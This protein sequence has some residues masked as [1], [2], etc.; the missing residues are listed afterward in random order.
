MAARMK[1]TDSRRR[2][3]FR[4]PTVRFEKFHSGRVRDTISGCTVFGCARGGAAM[5]EEDRS[6]N[7]IWL[8]A[9]VITAINGG[10]FLAFFA[11]IAGL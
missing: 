7:G 2:E 1:T 10:L 9:I 8:P 3:K 5:A 11:G 6:M 4:E